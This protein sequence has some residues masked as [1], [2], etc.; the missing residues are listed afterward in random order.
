[1]KGTRLRLCK[2]TNKWKRNFSKKY[3]VRLDEILKKEHLKSFK[4]LKSGDVI[5]NEVLSNLEIKD[6]WKLKFKNN[7]V[8]D[9]ISQ[10]KEQFDKA[11][12]DIKLRFEDKVLKIKQGDVTFYPQL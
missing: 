4:S 6:Y 5:S 8:N 3:S 7:V 12:E 10:L 1:M 2:K 9:K 11:N